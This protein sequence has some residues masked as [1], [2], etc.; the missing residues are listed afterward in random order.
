[1]IVGLNRIAAGR[2]DDGEDEDADEH[3]APV[4]TQALDADDAD[5]AT[6]ARCT[7][8]NCIT[9]PKARNSVVT[10]PK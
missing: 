8:G 10:K 4:A 5:L 1:M 2:H 9:S 3:V 6:A 7:I